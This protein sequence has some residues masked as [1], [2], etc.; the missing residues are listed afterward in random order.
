MT[1]DTSRENE[2]DPLFQPLR[3]KHLTLKNRIGDAVSSR[4]V[5]AA[6]LDAFRISVAF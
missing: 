6:L 1:Q 5:H 2:K 3:I 4:S